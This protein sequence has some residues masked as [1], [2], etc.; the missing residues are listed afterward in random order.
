MTADVLAVIDVYATGMQ[1]ATWIWITTAL[2]LT[3]AGAW[4]IAAIGRRVI[5]SFAHANR[6][7]RHTAID[8]TREETP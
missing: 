5:D 4:L 8:H 6:L 1:W 3:L 2:G 7:V